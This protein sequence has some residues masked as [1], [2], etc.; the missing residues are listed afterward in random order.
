MAK[1]G[2]IARNSGLVTAEGRRRS[3]LNSLKHGLTAR[4]GILDD[5]DAEEFDLHRRSTVAALHPIGSVELT[6]AEVIVSVSWRL[7]R[8]AIVEAEQLEKARPKPQSIAAPVTRTGLGEAFAVGVT[9]GVWATL[10]RYESHLI[11]SLTRALHELERLQL[12]RSGASVP[13]PLVL[14]VDVT[15]ADQ[16]A[17]EPGLVSVD[18]ILKR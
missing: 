17:D 2:P 6:L 11:R 10:Q 12:R 3:A 8:T 14:D 9:H 18:P 7:R 1:S 4:R 5:E 16:R 15:A 13:P